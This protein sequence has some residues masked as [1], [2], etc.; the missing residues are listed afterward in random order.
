MAQ[1]ATGQW[2]KYSDYQP[3]RHDGMH[4]RL[5]TLQKGASPKNLQYNLQHAELNHCPRYSAVSYSWGAPVPATALKKIF[6]HSKAVW[7]RP[8]LYKFLKNVAIQCPSMNMWI[9][10]LC[11]DQRNTSERNHQISIMGDI[12]KTAQDVFVWLGPGDD[13]TDYAM[14]HIGTADPST[15]FD[16][17]IFSR[18]VQKLFTATYWS[19]RWVIQEF[20]LAQ[21]LIVVCGKHLTS[22]NTLTQKI[23]ARVIEGDVSA[24]IAF[25]NF[26]RL[27]QLVFQEQVSL[28][29]LMARFNRARCVD[30]R[31]KVFA[32]RSIAKDGQRLKVDYN[33][34]AVDVYFRVLSLLPT[35]R[36][37]PD[38]WGYRWPDQAASQLLELMQITRQELLSCLVDN[39]DDRL[40]A[41]LEYKGKIAIAQESW[42]TDRPPPSKTPF[43]SFPHKVKL[44]GSY[45]TVLSGCGN[46]R[47]GDR[48]YSLRS[49]PKSPE[50]LYI[51]F[52]SGLQDSTVA[53]LL[54]DLPDL[55]AV[56]YWMRMGLSEVAM[57]RIKE[58]VSQGVVP[59]SRNYST[60]SP[61][62]RILCHVDRR[63]LLLLWLMDNGLIDELLRHHPT[64]R[65]ESVGAKLKCSCLQEEEHA[66][67]N[68]FV[69]SYKAKQDCME[70][71][72]SF[73]TPDT[74]QLWTVS[75]PHSSAVQG[76]GLASPSQG[77]LEEVK[78]PWQ[79][80]DS[81]DFISHGRTELSFAAIDGHV[82]FVEKLLSD[83]HVEINTRDRTGRTPLLL[84]A[85]HGHDEVVRLLVSHSDIEYNCEDE[86]GNNALSLAIE[87]GHT[88]V[89]E[90]LLGC[91]KFSHS[92]VI[93]NEYDGFVE[94]LLD[95]NKFSPSRLLTSGHLPL[96][97]A[98]KHGHEWVVRALLDLG[99]A[100]P[101]QK[102]RLGLTPLL[103]AAAYGQC[104]VV[105]MLL[106]TG[107]V[108]LNFVDSFNRTA[109]FLAAEYGHADI[110][111]LL[112]S[113]R[114]VDAESKNAT[115]QT[116]LW[117][118]AQN[119]HA[120]VVQM[121]FDTGKVD[122]DY[123]FVDRRTA[124]TPLHR[125]VD[126]D[127]Y[128]VA[129]ALIAT[130]RVDVNCT[131]ETGYSAFY[132]AMSH[133]NAKIMR[134]LLGT[135]KVDLSAGDTTGE[136]PLHKAILW[137]SAQAVRILLDTGKFDINRKDKEG[138]SPIDWAAEYWHTEIL[139][140]F[141]DYEEG[142]QTPTQRS[143]VWQWVREKT[144]RQHPRIL[145]Y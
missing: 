139:Q 133:R 17:T 27:N 112:L 83:S 21:D 88:K 41:V 14:E 119:G 122:P 59:C 100:D 1:T 101:S 37:L 95:S 137:N 34:S 58:V 87:N 116:P 45:D 2:P 114:K 130:N 44:Y 125:A 68:S 69:V 4:I 85:E 82:G 79:G 6:I 66:H 77:G 57:Q 16:P 105:K 92:L 61:V 71:L 64:P 115:G 132:T 51:A 80:P 28:L 142:I 84:A 49:T 138:K 102:D 11:I 128:D 117:V 22:W 70:I 72:P 90:V 8:T 120:K 91:E 143:Q 145:P 12:Y 67:A 107:Q 56:S 62:S 3:L 36:V 39:P 131:A 63:S 98:A 48:V 118:A 99:K 126:K 18:C 53:G 9:D 30:Q 94:V 75:V 81:L 20:A 134:L 15:P 40:Y 29:L 7:V 141:K 42:P 47:S 124:S 140:V 24:Q 89:V 54:I 93:N 135:G 86:R 38:V 123:L 109:L 127:H 110:V 46:F 74:K 108:D 19:R 113:T 31:D 136:T 129:A 103:T 73:H 10:C 65:H 35:Q 106:D 50:G 97:L 43:P 25:D 78:S 32:L 111:D 52:R 5:L 60:K 23:D 33:E 121:L 13:E 26:K 144:S 76:T 104:K 55:E 96:T